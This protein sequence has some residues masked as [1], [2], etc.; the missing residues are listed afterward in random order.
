VYAPALVCFVVARDSCFLYLNE[1]IVVSC[2]ADTI[3]F[4][5]DIKQS[6]GSVTNDS[7]EVRRRRSQLVG[8]HYEG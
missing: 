3:P 1:A 2:L 4:M 5:S 8:L 7:K 6:Q